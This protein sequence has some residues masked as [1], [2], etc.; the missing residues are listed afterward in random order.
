[1][2]VL[3][4]YRL[5]D[6]YKVMP[7]TAFFTSVVWFSFCYHTFTQK[8]NWL[9]AY[10]LC[11]SYTLKTWTPSQLLWANGFDHE[12]AIILS[13]KKQKSHSLPFYSQLWH[14]SSSGSIYWCCTQLLISPQ[15]N[16]KNVQIEPYCLHMGVI[17]VLCILL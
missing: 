6:F 7:V 4:Q 3:Y 9:K 13:L 2:V 1:M 17:L 16:K 12:L 8:I 5:L 10:K 14:D 15:T 11:I